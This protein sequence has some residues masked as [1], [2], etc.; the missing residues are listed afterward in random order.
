[1]EHFYIRPDVC[2][3]TIFSKNEMFWVKQDQVCNF[4][5]IFMCL[6]VLFCFVRFRCTLRLLRKGYHVLAEPWQ[7]STGTDAHSKCSAIY[8]IFISV[9]V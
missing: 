4:F 5:E 1:M 8:I 6:F 3:Y 2:C 7:P 9:E